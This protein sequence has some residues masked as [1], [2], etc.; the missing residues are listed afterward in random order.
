MDQ[1]IYKVV[2]RELWARAESAGAFTGSP[3]DAADGYIHFSARGQLAETVAK[4]FAGQTDLL[5]VTVDA[6]LLGEQL[7]WETS[8]HNELFPHLYGVLPLSAVES[9]DELPLGQD[10]RHIFPRGVARDSL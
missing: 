1:R 7:K 2:P 3:I 6:Q 8:R 9:V 10:G 4:H 5:L